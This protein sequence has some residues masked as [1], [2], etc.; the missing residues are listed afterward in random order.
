MNRQVQSEIRQGFKE[1]LDYN[2]L[3]NCMRC[4]FCLPTCPTYGQ[5][6]Q[7]EAASPRGRIAL[8]KGVVDG[9]IEPDEDVEKQ[10]NLCLGCRACEPV[11]PSGVKY[12]HLLEEARDVIQQKKKH[13][14]HV[15]V[16]LG[17]VFKQL[18]PHKDRIKR[19]HYFLRFYQKSGLQRIV[20]KSK[21][22][23]ILPGNIAELERTIPPIASAGA[24]NNRPAYLPAEGQAKKKVAFF[25]GCLMDT[26][27]METNDAT[28]K[29][30]QKAGCDIVIP[31]GQGCCG[32][33]HAHGGEKE[34]AKRLAK[35]NIEAFESLD[36]D[37]IVLNAGGCGAL[38]V[39]YDHL[40]RDEEEW[41]ER[42]KAF[43]GKVRDFSE[44]LVELQFAERELSLPKQVIT[45]QD[46]C[47]LRNVMGT[48]SAPRT[49]LASIKGVQYRE[50]EEADHCC[51]SAGVYN[52]TEKEMSMQIL[53]YKM[54]KVNKVRA[55]TIVTA[56]PG[57]LLQMRLG[58]IREGAEERMR[59]VH[60]A[61][62]LLE[63]V[64]GQGVS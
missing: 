46:S 39:E 19:L 23:H 24:L 7:Y 43:A 14:M 52:I 35:A 25:S 61:D 48:A 17:L 1:Q 64:N 21:L 56:N 13:K 53:D 49:L 55:Q 29:L 54:E 18:F 41:R 16:M 3:M 20:Q 44:I 42:A 28:M 27:F 11:C 57:C 10:L 22:L 40:L 58:I 63:A 15:K 4:G 62:L 26:M 47:H 34:M 45:Y 8:M 2:E 38:L 50:M 31:S 36:V 6:D 51:G 59:A 60:L 12:G 9:V 5:T 37:Y 33:L 30:L 32:A